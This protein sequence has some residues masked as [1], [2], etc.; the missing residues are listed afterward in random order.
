MVHPLLTDELNDIPS[1]L[2]QIT[3]T[4]KIRVL[5]MLGLI[6][7]GMAVVVAAETAS[8]V[9]I[10]LFAAL[11]GLG[12]ILALSVTFHTEICLYRAIE[13]IRQLKH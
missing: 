9:A 2:Q 8:T 11:A 7:I 4:Y 13:E 3:G 1:R 12:A 6:A 10:G 5:L